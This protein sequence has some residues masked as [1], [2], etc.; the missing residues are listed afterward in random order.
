[1]KV[2]RAAA[3]SGATLPR[4]PHSPQSSVRQCHTAVNSDAQTTFLAVSTLLKAP[5]QS[6]APQ[7]QLTRLVE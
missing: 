6:R 4:R 2:A 1:M 7:A 5:A 3:V